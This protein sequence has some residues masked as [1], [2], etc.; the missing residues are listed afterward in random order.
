MLDR[1][2]GK[3]PIDPR[4]RPETGRAV[5][6]QGGEYILPLLDSVLAVW[7]LKVKYKAVGVG[8]DQDRVATVGAA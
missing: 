3:Q 6:G 1:G 2:L 8:G 7:W 4:D 5:C